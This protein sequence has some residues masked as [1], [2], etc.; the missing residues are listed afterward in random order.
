MACYR[1][2]IE[3][4]SNVRFGSLAGL[5]PDKNEDRFTVSAIYTQPFGNDNIWSPPASV[6]VANSTAGGHYPRSYHHA[7]RIVFCRHPLNAPSL[8]RVKHLPIGSW[9][10]RRPGIQTFAFDNRGILP[11][12]T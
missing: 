9:Y 4:I 12:R 8:R 3:S 7:R 6:P 10:H 5:E 2:F 1:A 11:W